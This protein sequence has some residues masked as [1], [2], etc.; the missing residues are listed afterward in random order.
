MVPIVTSMPSTAA[1]NAACAPNLYS[2]LHHK[3]SLVGSTY[4]ELVLRLQQAAWEVFA[5]GRVGP[6]LSMQLFQSW[7]RL[8]HFWIRISNIG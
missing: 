3:V 5:A 7:N 1:L 2:L 8:V 4:S 6:S